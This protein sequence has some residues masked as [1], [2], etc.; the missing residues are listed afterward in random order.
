MKLRKTFL[1]SLS[2]STLG[3][4]FAVPALAQT[5][6]E[7]TVHSPLPQTVQPIFDNAIAT[8]NTDITNADTSNTEVNSA[9]ANDAATTNAATINATVLTDSPNNE[10]NLAYSTSASDLAPS[11]GTEMTAEI[12]QMDEPEATPLMP[13]ETRILGDQVNWEI[14]TDV[15]FLRRNIP[16]V[17]TSIDS[18]IDTL[19]NTLIGSNASLGS[20]SLGFDLAA[21]GRFTA[22]YYPTLRSGF[23]VSFMGLVDWNDSETFVSDSGE[24]LRASFVDPVRAGQDD[25]IALSPR[26]T[27]QV[28]DFVAARSQRLDYESDLDSLELNYRYALTS[29]SDR[30][31][32]TLVAGFRYMSIDEEF[33]FTS[34]D[35]ASRLGGRLGTYE[36]DTSNDL[37]GLQIGVDS[38]VQITRNLGLDVRV[39]GGL[40]LNFNDQSSTFVND[41]GIPT[42]LSGSESDT[43]LASL[44]ELEGSASWDIGDNFT[45]KAGYQLLALSGIA[46]AP[47]Q[48][49]PLDELGDLN[50]SSV[51][52]HGPFVGLELRF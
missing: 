31:Y 50:R 33:M 1:L 3:C 21:G 36:I 43:S 28:E 5:E 26:N 48:F 51:I 8:S 18:Q 11:D 25:D 46:L 47:S 6:L 49:G 10:T 23:E 17:I 19:T 38:G 20:E 27:N 40:M 42:V 39:R 24:T 30:S 13:I 34:N 4:C 45:L 37:L 9:E 22:G 41:N 52:Y 12:A 7:N 32:T 2:A 15:V 16:D 29:P 44:V 35:G 14:N